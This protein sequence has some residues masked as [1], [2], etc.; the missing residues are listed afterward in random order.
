[1]KNIIKSGLTILLSETLLGFLAI[2]SVALTIAPSIFIL[3]DQSQVVIE[4][5]QWCI[6][7]LFGIEYFYGLFTTTDRQ[8][9]L[10]NG[11][12]LVDL[13]TFLIPLLTV[14]PGV[15]EYFRSALLL[16]LIRLTRVIAL[17]LRATG[18]VTRKEGKQKFE[19]QS[20]GEVKITL[21][22]DKI[23][24]APESISW[25]EFLKITQSQ[26]PTFFNI[27]NISREEA[28]VISKK[29]GLGDNFLDLHLFSTGYP[30]LETIKDNLALF[31][32]FP[33]LLSG[34]RAVRNAV[35]LIAG[36]NILLT[37]SKNPTGLVEDIANS[38]F[39]AEQLEGLSFLQKMLLII[40]QNVVN[41]NEAVAGKYEDELRGLEEIPVRESRQQFFEHTFQLK[42]ELSA[43]AAD[44]WRLKRILNEMSDA[45]ELSSELMSEK[46]RNHI[47][48]LTE[49]VEYLYETVVNIREG[50]LSV[51]E[52]HLNVVS[53]EMNRVMRV[54]A[55]VSVLGLIP[56][57]VGGMLGMNLIDNPWKFT[58]P[59]VV[60]FVVFSMISCLYIFFIKGWLR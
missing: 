27:S 53:F 6:I 11:W 22:K 42:K 26:S 2:V 28:A 45:G 51:I 4:I 32:W 35:L 15:S 47:K 60:F 18:I 43:L 3:S 36:D 44:L 48:N 50:V 49:D 29:F 10:K 39:P 13:G 20:K 1:M 14:I 31:L 24:G 55:V 58:L 57:V 40:L 41:K 38:T 16:R 30:H 34:G 12:K 7:G 9:Y 56:G 54:L 17:G 33:R 21:M 25:E 59:Q 37:L 19:L 8:N 5:I 46:M 52:L 23:P